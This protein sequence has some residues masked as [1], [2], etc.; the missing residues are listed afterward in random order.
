MSGP[1]TPLMTIQPQNF[2]GVHSGEPGQPPPPVARVGLVKDYGDLVFNEAEVV[3][4][5]TRIR[6]IGVLPAGTC[7]VMW[8]IEGTGS[9]PFTAEHFDGGVLPSDQVIF[10][11]GGSQEHTLLFALAAVVPPVLPLTGQIRLDSPVGCEIIP[12]GA[13]IPMV[14]TEA[15]IT[16]DDALVGLSVPFSV[17]A[18]DAP[19]AGRA[20][21]NAA[22]V[23]WKNA[24][25]EEWKAA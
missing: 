23:S 20:W 6:R 9:N 14:A 1:S 21:V 25:G 12:S 16:L 2:G 7:S 18:R 22:G 5:S 10:S 24:A 4:Y 13:I 8:H 11:A 17:I 15:I 3:F 19:P